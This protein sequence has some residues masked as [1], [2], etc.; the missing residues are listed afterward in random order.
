MSDESPLKKVRAAVKKVLKKNDPS[1]EV[2]PNAMKQSLPHFPT[3]ST[4]LDYLIGGMPNKYGVAPCPGWPKGKIS[5]IYGH[6][7]S[8]KT[9]IALEAA[10]GVIASGGCVTFIDWEHAIDLSY[11]QSLGV[12]TDDDDKFYL[13]QPLTLED[14]MKVLWTAAC[15]GVDLIILDSIGAGVPETIFNQTMDEQGNIG[16]VGLLA[17]KWS[18]FLPKVHALISKTG[19]HVMGISQLRAK[20]NTMGYGPSTTQQGG[21]AWK[22]YTSLRMEFRRIQSE[23][24]RV[25]DAIENKMVEKV[26]ANLIRAKI[27]K[28]KVSPSQQHEGTFWVIFGKGIDDMRTIVD[29]CA[30]HN[31]ISKGGAWYKYTTG[32]GQEK[33]FHGY[34]KLVEEIENNPALYEDMRRAA[35]EKLQAYGNAPVGVPEEVEEEGADDLANMSFD[36]LGIN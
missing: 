5:Q 18:A 31:V 4:S 24:T 35:I 33:K 20:I 29:I 13:V 7:S 1:I 9:T 8:G 12:P 23:K 30:A 3:G 11:A 28:S 22:F 36:D 27:E 6:E 19:S 14:G 25:Y 32:D 16:R 10:A 26:T 17:A 15:A 2:D 34:P 21:E